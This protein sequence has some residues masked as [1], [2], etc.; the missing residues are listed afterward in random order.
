M[1]SLSSYSRE[2]ECRISTGGLPDAIVATRPCFIATSILS[3]MVSHH[4]LVEHNTIKTKQKRTQG[5]ILSSL[6]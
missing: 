2:A 3:F 4:E 1:R 5:R 6:I